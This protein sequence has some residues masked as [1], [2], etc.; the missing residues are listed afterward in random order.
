[1]LIGVPKET[2]DHE[3]RVGLTPESVATLTAHGHR[4]L[5]EHDA[6]AAVGFSNDDYLKAGAD[7]V[8][9]GADVY[10]AEMIVKVKEP[11]SDECELLRKGQILFSYLHLV[12]HP[13]VTAALMKSGATC[14]AYETITAPDGSRPLLIPMSAIAGRL[15]IQVGAHYLEKPH[16]R[17]GLL[18][19]G[20]PGTAPA[21]VTVLGAGTVG[22]YAAEIARGMRA[23]TFILD[24]S[25]RALQRAQKRLGD[26]V[27]PVLAADGDDFRR[28]LVDAD[29]VV[30]AL[31]VPGGRTPQIA[32]RSTVASM[33]PGAVIVDVAADQ[34]GCFETSRPTTHSRPTY[35]EEGVVHY[36]VTNMPGVVPLTSTLS[37]NHATLA[38]AA[39]IAGRGW[40]RSLR[41]DPG[42]AEGLSICDGAM[43]SRQTAADLG[44]DYRDPRTFL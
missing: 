22:V 43:T 9:G 24:K 14:I 21:K 27:V 18:L 16:G 33:Q 42:F 19:S 13:T 36:C 5:V 7:V 39:A 4:L 6:G 38:Y 3:Y 41:D 10:V 8:R 20:A 32:D 15:A 12:A 31:L 34:G 29:L 2:K 30:G 1:M 11:Q 40:R 17:R 35:V 23:E 44:L 26:N 37:L 28:Y 25:E